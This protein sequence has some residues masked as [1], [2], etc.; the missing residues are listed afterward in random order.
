MIM[1]RVYVGDAAGG[2]VDYS[3]PFAETQAETLDMPPLAPGAR[4]WV[5]VRFL[6]T[7]TGLEELNTDAKFLIS[8]DEVGNDVSIVP[9]SPAGLSIRDSGPDSAILIWQYNF[10][11]G[12]EIP[13]AWDVYAGVAVDYTAPVGSVAHN[14]FK[15]RF[16]YE[17]TGFTPG[18]P[19]V[20]AVRSRKGAAHDPNTARLTWNPAGTPQPATRPSAEITDIEI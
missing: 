11:D 15:V 5:G 14:P 18:I 12:D 3:A 8:V 7:D 4:Q 6:D 10:R 19:L 16:S 2:P 17:L 13:D 9:P 20:V 1:A